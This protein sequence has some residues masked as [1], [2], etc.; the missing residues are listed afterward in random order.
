MIESGS[1]PI[2]E[3]D[4]L[5]TE[6]HALVGSL[7]AEKVET[8]G[9][10]AEGWSAKDLF[11]HI[12]SWLAE[13]GAVLE[14]IRFGTYRPEE[15]DIDV[16]N[17]RFYEAMKDVP[18]ATVRSQTTAARNRMLQAWGAVDER[19]P[20]AQRWIR[21]AGPEHYAEHLPRLREW[22]AELTG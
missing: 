5:W 11:A 20:D 12:G 14:R 15:I 13:A 4:R 8:P 6:L 17:A 19:E 3:E 10:F 21:K 16:L 7:P 22:A 1:D 2:D 9:Y 18:F